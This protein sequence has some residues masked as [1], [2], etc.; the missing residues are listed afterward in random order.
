MHWINLYYISKHIVKQSVTCVQ[1]F[2]YLNQFRLIQIHS[3][4]DRINVY[5]L[6]HPKIDQI[7]KFPLKLYEC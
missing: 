3:D 6:N 1:T 2:D 4:H 7:G 5:D